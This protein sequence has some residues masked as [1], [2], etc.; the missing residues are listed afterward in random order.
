MNETQRIAAKRHAWMTPLIA[1]LKRHELKNLISR[2]STTTAQLWTLELLTSH[3]L[4]LEPVY[5]S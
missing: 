5:E 3:D 1:I 4:L 2:I